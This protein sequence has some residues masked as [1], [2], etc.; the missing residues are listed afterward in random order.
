MPTSKSATSTSFGSLKQIDAPTDDSDSTVWTNQAYDLICAREHRFEGWFGSAE[1]FARQR[2][3]ALIRCP[4]CDDAGIER[5]PSAQVRI[6]RAA[7]PAEARTETTQTTAVAG[8]DGET[9]KLVR[10]LVASTEN[11]GRAFA[12]EARKIHYEEAPPRGKNVRHRI[13]SAAPSASV[14]TAY[15]IANAVE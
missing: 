14:V 9:L 2:D 3:G 8:G 11:V 12:E 4:L 10:R 6:G 15:Q 5:R 13:A 7:P 1:D